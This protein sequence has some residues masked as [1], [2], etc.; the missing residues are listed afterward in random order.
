M[1]TEKVI[2][3]IATVETYCR[4]MHWAVVAIVSKN[5]GDEYVIATFYSEHD[6]EH[7]VDS[8]PPQNLEVRKIVNA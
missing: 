7:F 6:A 2:K 4:P 8:M 1:K 5:I 3:Q